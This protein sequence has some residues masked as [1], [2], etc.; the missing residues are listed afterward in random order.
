MK[1]IFH[2]VSSLEEKKQVEEP[3]QVKRTRE[4][5]KPSSALCRHPGQVRGQYVSVDLFRNS[6]FVEFLDYFGRFSIQIV[7]VIYW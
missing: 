5:V 7:G 2:P 6:G 1:I 3:I 4:I